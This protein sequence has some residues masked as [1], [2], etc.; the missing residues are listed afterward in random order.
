MKNR[1]KINLCGWK[2]AGAILLFLT[3]ATMGLSA[4]T[5]T[6]LVNFNGSRGT[7]PSMT[8]ILGFD[9]NYY[10]ATFGGGA[11]CPQGSTCGTIYRLTPSGRMTT[12]YTFC[13]QSGCPDGSGPGELTQARDGNLYGETGAGGANGGGTFFRM[14]LSGK[15]TTLYSFCAPSSCGYGSVPTVVVEASDGNFYGTTQLGGAYGYGAIVRISPS[16]RLT[17]VHSFNNNDGANPV[18]GLIQGA[19]GNLYGTTSG[20]GNLNCDWG[21]NFGPG[22]G[23]IFKLT[24]KGSFSTLYSFCPLSCSDGAIPWGRIV[25]DADGNLY[26]TT[27]NGGNAYSESECDPIG[28]GT[29]FEF[30]QQGEL[31]TLYKFCEFGPGACNDGYWPF[32]GLTLGSDGNLYGTTSGG[33]SDNCS[34]SCG[35]LF[36]ITPNGVYTSLHDF[37]GVDG[38]YPRAITQ[39]TNGIFLGVTASGGAADAGTLYSLSMNLPGFVETNPGFG[40]VGTQVVILGNNLKG[41]T[42]VTFN[43]TP[44]QFRVAGKSAILAVVPTGA[45]SGFISVATPKGAL[46]SNVQFVVTP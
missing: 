36:T 27:Q 43:G 24:P 3:L 40:K 13:R 38:D 30:T 23:T 14:S 15:L 33:V 5:F 6:T 41:S 11:N 35:A 26:G 42:A 20:G 29:V 19:N 44:A 12:V 25:E 28:C 17:T 22:C 31:S 21:V 1:L 34:D 32:E 37:D 7:N 46:S 18:G 8:P 45:T 9:G 2:S 16:G 10:G 39:A 4:Q